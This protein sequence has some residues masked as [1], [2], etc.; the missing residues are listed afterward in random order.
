MLDSTAAIDMTIIDGNSMLSVVDLI[1]SFRINAMLQ[2]KEAKY[3][4]TV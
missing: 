3:V 4:W 2:E 1:A